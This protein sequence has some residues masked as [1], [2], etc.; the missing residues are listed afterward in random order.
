MNDGERIGGGRAGRRRPENRVRGW[1]VGV[2]QERGGLIDNLHPL[3]RVSGDMIESSQAEPI[4]DGG[5]AES[6]SAVAGSRSSP[7]AIYI[8]AWADLLR[9]KRGKEKEDW[10]GLGFIICFLFFF[11]SPSDKEVLTCCR[12]RS[13]LPGRWHLH[14]LSTGQFVNK[15]VSD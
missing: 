2:G 14:E 3:Q 5:R 9:Q 4:R 10:S 11:F 8:H 6:D 13:L 12:H 1:G 7:V 15:L